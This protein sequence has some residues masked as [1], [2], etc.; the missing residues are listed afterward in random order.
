MTRTC[1]GF[2]KPPM[3]WTGLFLVSVVILAVV[4]IVWDPGY[5]RE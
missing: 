5:N 4:L 1:A 2:T 3:F